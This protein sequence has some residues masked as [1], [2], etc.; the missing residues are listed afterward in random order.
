MPTSL[1]LGTKI[2]VIEDIEAFA[3]VRLNSLT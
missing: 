1:E 3:C 2:Y